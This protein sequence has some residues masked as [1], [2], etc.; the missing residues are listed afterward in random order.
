MRLSGHG[1]TTDLPAGWE[2]RIT[3][4]V[5]P[6]GRAD[7]RGTLG[8]VP[9]PVVHL[10]NFALPEQRGDFGSGAVDLMG[11]GHVLLT[12]FE[13][14]PDSGGRA[15]TIGDG[16]GTTMGVDIRIILSPERAR[17]LAQSLF[18]ESLAI[19]TLADASAPEP[20]PPER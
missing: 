19:E 10:A 20:L 2:G 18:S 17:E 16:A 5:T 6:T 3:K 14:G 12:L 11:S 15:L 4:R 13:Y 7:G 8:E 9:G 1:I